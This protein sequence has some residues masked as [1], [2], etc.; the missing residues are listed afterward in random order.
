MPLQNWVEGL[1]SDKIAGPTLASSVTATSILNVV[2][3][4]PMPQ[5]FW[6]VGRKLRVTATGQISNITPTPGTVTIDLR[7][8]PTSNFIVWNGGA[9]S[10]VSN[11]SSAMAV[12]VWVARELA[13]SPP[14]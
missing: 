7:M 3:K 11:R 2:D 6:Y 10:M 1:V 4:Y 12:T 13:T 14:A 9:M 5:G 8:G